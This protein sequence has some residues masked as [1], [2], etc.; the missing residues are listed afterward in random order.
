MSLVEC[1]G[2]DN[3]PMTIIISD[4]EISMHHT[5]GR[6]RRVLF[7]VDT[8]FRLDELSHGAAYSQ[9]MP[10]RTMQPL[11]LNDLSGLRIAASLYP[12]SG[13][14]ATECDKYI[15]EVKYRRE[16]NDRIAAEVKRITNLEREI[17]ELQELRDK[18]AIENK[19]LRGNNKILQSKIDSVC[20]TSL[21]SVDTIQM[22]R[23]ENARLKS[24]QTENTLF[25]KSMGI[26]RKQGA[27]IDD[28]DGA[29]KKLQEEIESLKSK[30]KFY[31]DH[32]S[33]NKELREQIT[34]LQ[35]NKE[36]LQ[37]SALQ[38]SELI[39][40][41]VNKETERLQ[42]ANKELH[43]ALCDSKLSVVS[44]REE[45][46][47]LKKKAIEREERVVDLKSKRDALDQSL[48][49]S[50]SR[51]RA[52]YNA[53]YKEIEELKASRDYVSRLRHTIC[54]TKKYWLDDVNQKHSD[55]LKDVVKAL[56]KK[57]VAK[58]EKIIAEKEKFAKR[59]FELTE[60][61]ASLKQVDDSKS[62]VQSLKLQLAT[63][64]RISQKYARDLQQRD[65]QQATLTAM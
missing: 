16:K 23:M 38:S 10:G 52:K 25:Q 61:I 20:F 36:S 48:T 30:L 43:R 29:N 35:S 50:K 27:V 47:V 42:S 37:R 26:A 1:G 58:R 64:K 5:D 40:S 59:V 2:N 9:T 22:L 14:K 4:T 60:E 62:Q 11:T 57:H 44:L 49:E 41:A 56:G 24:A 8:A 7:K 46:S 53:L 3:E 54:P 39:K 13:G 19:D 6:Y 31:R 65:K 55:K 15:A 63:E 28:M 12:G 21:H 34:I 51:M 17:K 33:E 18:N 32:A 45:I